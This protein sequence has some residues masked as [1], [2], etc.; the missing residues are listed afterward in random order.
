MVERIKSQL[1]KHRRDIAVL[2][3]YAVLTLLLTWPLFTQMSTHLVGD[4]VDVWI[5]PWADWWTQKALTEG[6]DLFHTDYMFYPQGTSLVFHSFSHFNTALSLSLAPLLGS[7]AAYNL[8]ILLAFALS[9]FG[10]YL[11]VN[12]L[13]RCPPA[14]FVAGVVFTF[15]PYHMFQ[16]SHPVIVTTQFVPLFAL[17]LM[18]VLYAGDTDR[19][20]QV[21]LAVLWFGLTVLSSWHLAIMLASWATLYLLYEL[22]FERTEWSPGASRAL[23]ILLILIALV[24]TPLL[25]PIVQEQ[26]T[27]GISYMTVDVQE[28]R[29]NDLLSF[30]TPNRK[31]PLF[32]SLVLDLNVR[33]GYTR[34]TPAYLG[35]GAVALA[36]IGVATAR[37]KTR[38]WWLSGLFFL[39]LSLGSLIKWAG[40]PLFTFHLPWATPITAVLRHPFRLNLLLFFSLAVLVGFGGR[41]LYDWLVSRGKPVAY[42]VLVSVTAFLLL[43]YWVSPFPI[44]QPSYSPFW[45]QLAHEEGDFAVANF[46]MGRQPAKYY[47]FLQ[48][49]HGKKIVDGVVSR[50]PHDAYAFVDANPLLGAM[51]NENV[52]DLYIKERLAV[53]A[54]QDIRY[55][56]VHKY[57]LDPTRMENWQKW[58]VHFPPPFYEDERLIVYRTAPDLQTG[59][60]NQ[61]LHRLDARLGDHVGLRGY[62]LN[63]GSLSAGEALTVTLFW[64]AEARM[65]ESYHVFVH[66]LN[67]EQILVAQHDGVPVNGERPTWSWWG[68]EVIPDE[69]TLVVTPDLPSG[70]YTLSTGM[71]DPATG[72]R[73][74]ATNPAGERLP[75]NRMVLGEIEVRSP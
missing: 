55:I 67:A 72:E 58:L 59:L 64:Q 60:L 16:S 57:F 18:R 17:A 69:H 68:A 53:L 6:L 21:L 1:Q 42:L 44:T 15:H 43:E 35:Y 32:A 8:T 34:N 30:F 2:G 12:D 27:A 48:T 25:W 41:W 71:Y 70:V 56:V 23:L 47:L 5:N 39:L 74:P 14:A 38:F 54:A 13:T 36:L 22:R 11:L 73:L 24:V 29:G 7:W 46:P 51:R 62:Q 40:V 49:I 50:T 31:H 9:G 3:I 37:R 19:G 26:L 4:D 66:L 45:D 65:D 20:K 75:E 28:G 61:D 52:P 63:A 33:I 10:M